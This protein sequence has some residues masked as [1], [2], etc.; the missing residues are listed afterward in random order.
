MFSL[1]YA[2]LDLKVPNVIFQNGAKTLPDGA[3]H[4]YIAYIREYP[5]PS[6]GLNL[7]PKF[8]GLTSIIKSIGRQD[9]SIKSVYMCRK[10]IMIIV[11]IKNL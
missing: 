9:P 10:I 5:A 2:S 6:P 7:K 8:E 3:A 4:I 1:P 11:I